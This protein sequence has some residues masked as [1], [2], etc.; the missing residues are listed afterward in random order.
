MKAE[1]DFLARRGLVKHYIKEDIVFF[2]IPGLIV[3]GAGVSLSRMAGMLN[4][5]ELITQPPNLFTLP[6]H[7]I[8]G[9]AIVIAGFSLMIGAHII[10]RWSHVS[11][12]AIRENHKLRTNGL[13]RFVRHPMYF[14]AVLIS[15]GLPISVAS[16]EG[17]LVMLLII[18]VALSR[19]RIEERMMIEAF[20]NRYRNYMKTAKKLFPF[21]Y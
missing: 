12:L 17:F 9:A 13:Y 7:T 6:M 19:I 2:A 4:L 16:L 20:G 14:G 15:L 10:L 5:V 8:L 18:P 3:F 21:V 11:T 1:K